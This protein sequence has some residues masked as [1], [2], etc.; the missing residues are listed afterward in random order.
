M[1]GFRPVDYALGNVE[2][3]L[4]E[5]VRAGD[6]QLQSLSRSEVNVS[7]VW[8]CAQRSERT[9]EKSPQISN[10]IAAT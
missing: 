7:G 9:G 8:R 3:E 6:R 4:R 5:K 1:V 2:S 10:C